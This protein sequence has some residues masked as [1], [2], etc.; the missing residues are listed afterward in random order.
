METN[1][2]T[3][4]QRL[5]KVEHNINMLEEAIMTLLNGEPKPPLLTDN[6][7]PFGHKI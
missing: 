7:N 1:N 6:T 4:E 2:Y 3:I 5:S